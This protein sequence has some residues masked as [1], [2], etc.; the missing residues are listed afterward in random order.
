ML[1]ANKLSIRFVVDD[2]G[3]ISPVY[4]YPS[5]PG[6]SSRANSGTINSLQITLLNLRTRRITF[7]VITEDLPA[8]EGS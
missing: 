2:G 7:K 1:S 6:N 3:I 4:N 8:G 5:Q